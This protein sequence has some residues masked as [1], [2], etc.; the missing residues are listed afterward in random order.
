VPQFVKQRALGREDFIEERL[1]QASTAAQ[2]S[3]HA[4]NHVREKH[5]KRSRALRDPGLN[6]GPVFDII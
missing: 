3:T 4:Q 5:L 6:L 2:I 1:S